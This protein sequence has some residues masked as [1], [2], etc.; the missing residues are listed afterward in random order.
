MNPTTGT[1]AR[2]LYLLAGCVDGQDGP[3]WH[4]AICREFGRL[5]QGWKDVKGT[6]I[7]FAIKGHNVPTNKT[8]AHMRMVADF[9]PQKPD[10][11]CIRNTVGGS[12]ISVDYD[13]GNPT[14]D[15]STAKILINSTL[16][17]QGDR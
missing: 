15:L 10:P 8:A 6:N 5:M 2:I 17:T 12:K 11:H 4:E 7:F 1:E 9:R 13:I 14:A 16:S 3:T